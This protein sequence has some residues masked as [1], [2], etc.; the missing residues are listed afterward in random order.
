MPTYLSIDKTKG[1]TK[2]ILENV[3]HLCKCLSRIIR[4]LLQ[5]KEFVQIYFFIFPSP[6]D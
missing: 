1:E 4:S 6:S 3:N 2:A 5:I